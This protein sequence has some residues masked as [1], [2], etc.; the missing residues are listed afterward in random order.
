MLQKIIGS[1]SE[2]FTIGIYGFGDGDYA[3]PICMR[4]RLTRSGHTG[5]AEVLDHPR[6]SAIT[7]RIAKW[8]EPIGPTNLQFRMEGDTAYLL[9]IN[10]RFSSSCSLRAAF[11]F[12]EAEMCIDDL[13]EHRRP[14]QPVIRRGYA[15]R[16]NEDFIGDVGDPL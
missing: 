15:H 13:I 2:E 11:G 12:N 1:D 3:G 14:P 4:R 6:L 5:E 10:P 16:Y 8:L 9:E 7:D